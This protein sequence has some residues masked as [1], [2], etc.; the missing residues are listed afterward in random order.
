MHAFK[1]CKF[2][3]IVEQLDNK[4]SSPVVN[5]IDE[6]LKDVTTRLKKEAKEIDSL[7]APYLVFVPKNSPTGLIFS[8]FLFFVLLTDA[9]SFFPL[10]SFIKS[11]SRPTTSAPSSFKCRCAKTRI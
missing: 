6:Q 7:S 5:K 10:F 3:F 1:D 11:S 2:M 4:S 9:V 8:I